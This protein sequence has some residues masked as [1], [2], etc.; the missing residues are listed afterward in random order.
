MKADFRSI[1][2]GFLLLAGSSLTAQNWIQRADFGGDIRMGMAAIGLNGKGYA[3]FGADTVANNLF[4]DWWEYDPVTDVWTQ[5]ANFPS[6]RRSGPAIFTGNSKIYIVGGGGNMMV[7]FSDTWE[8]DPTLNQWSPKLNLP[9]GTRNLAASF[10]IGN[11]GYICTGQGGSPIDMQSDFWEYDVLSGNW[12]Q[13]A[14]FPGGKRVWAS[15]FSVLGKGYVATGMDTAHNH[16]RDLWE[17]DPATDSWT[18]KADL[19]ANAEGRYCPVSFGIGNKGYLGT[20]VGPNLNYQ[21]NDFWEYNPLTDSWFQLVSEPSAGRCYA[22]GF[23]IGTNVYL[24]TGLFTSTQYYK[25]LWVLDVLLAGIDHP[26]N[27]FEYQLY[28]NP[29]YESAFLKIPQTENTIFNLY[30]LNG[31]KVRQLTITGTNTILKR[32]NLSCGLYLYSLEKE[33]KMLAKGKLMILD[34]K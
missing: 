1:F 30:D 22:S 4:R 21:L 15:G 18:R 13:K 9:A 31:N 24:G 33:G 16:N 20:G 28:P 25:D 32:E 14:S 19:P 26:E 8:Y 3:G 7:I 17:Y 27:Q 11:K 6:M 34:M 10:S 12:T 29:M 5:K 2:I 23:A